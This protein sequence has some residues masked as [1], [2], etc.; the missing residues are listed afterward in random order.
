MRKVTKWK[1]KGDGAIENI[2]INI[3]FRNGDRVES[4]IQ[5]FHNIEKLVRENPVLQRIVKGE[6][7]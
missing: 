5:R 3:R 4:F 2:E 1:N 6:I 7:A